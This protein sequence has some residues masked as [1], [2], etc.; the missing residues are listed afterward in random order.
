MNID[1]FNALASKSGIDVYGNAF[2]ESGYG[3]EFAFQLAYALQAY[4][5]AYHGGQWTDEY[6]ALSQLSVAPISFNMGMSNFDPESEPD[7]EHGDEYFSAREIYATMEATGK[8]KP[9]YEA[10]LW[11]CK[12]EKE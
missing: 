11:Y 8:W 9:Y 1:E 7:I 4:L 2:S 5:S 3:I 6:S 10:L 12:Q